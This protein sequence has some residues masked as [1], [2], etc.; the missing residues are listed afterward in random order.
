MPATMTK[1]CCMSWVNEARCE[2][3]DGGG[4]GERERERAH[5]AR[6]RVGVEAAPEPAD[7]LCG[8]LEA[9]HGRAGQER[10]RL[11]VGGVVEARCRVGGCER[12]GGCGGC[13]AD[14]GLVA[15]CGES[16]HAMSGARRER[17]RSRRGGADEDEPRWGTP[18]LRRV[19]R[20]MS[21]KHSRGP[22]AHKPQL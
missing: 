18:S 7:L 12:E 5:L 10:R 15:G 9:A 16:A 17:T 11:V 13:E 19:P 20:R 1:T 2:R 8:G 21:Y 4:E 22:S 14:L 3:P 6:D